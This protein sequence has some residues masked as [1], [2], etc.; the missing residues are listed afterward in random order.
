MT[1]PPL[2]R[3]AVYDMDLTITDR[4]SWTPWLLHWAWHEAP[5]RLLLA[6][7]L[8]VPALGFAL[9]LLGRKGLKQ[10]A[11]AVL[12][13][14]HVDARR[15]G[16]RAQRFAERFAARHERHDALC[17]IAADRAEGFRILIATA[18]SA[19]YVRAMAARWGVADVVA[20]A[21]V[22]SGGRVSHRIAG[23]NCYGADKLALVEAWCR[24]EGL[25]RET[26]E[27]RAYSDHPSDAP[28][29][30]WADAPAVIGPGRRMARL[31]A[32]RG[33]PVRRWKRRTAA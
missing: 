8:L 29:L 7:L 19:Y 22:E 12:M 26:M 30:A 33:W 32:A 28:L 16:H 24:A 17:Q 11:Q 20:T 4:A 9:G 15:I 1:G 18:S 5:W 25:R 13:G 14:R 27:V 21:N 2:Q 31:A 23:P 6:P 3:L 10:A